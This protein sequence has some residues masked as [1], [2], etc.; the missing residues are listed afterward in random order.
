MG[1]SPKDYDFVFC[2]N[3]ATTSDAGEEMLSELAELGWQP[4]TILRTHGLGLKARH[5]ETGQV[6]DFSATTKSLE[7]FLRSRDLT[8]NAMAQSFSGELIDLGGKGQFDL[9]RSLLRSHGDS[10]GTLASD[11]IRVL[12]V[13]RLKLSLDFRL[14]EELSE[15]YYD[16]GHLLAELLAYEELSDRRLLETN[17]VL[18]A[19]Q[20]AAVVSELAKLPE[21]LLTE[22]LSPVQKQMKLKLF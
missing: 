1:R 4:L 14:S 3:L 13:L 7:Q 15:L 5:S 17:R 22:V 20:P 16:K 19:A 12:R 10:F 8:I 9:A 2:S 6:C 18:S 11:A 21:T